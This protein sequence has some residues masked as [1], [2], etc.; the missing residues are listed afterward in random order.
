MD[1]SHEIDFPDIKDK[2]LLDVM[3]VCLQWLTDWLTDCFTEYVIKHMSAPLV[4]CN[5]HQHTFGLTK[6]A[7]A[8]API[9]FVWSSYP[10]FLVTL[11]DLKY[12]KTQ[13]S[14]QSDRSFFKM[15]AERIPALEKHLYFEKWKIYRRC[16]NCVFGIV[17]FSRLMISGKWLLR[18]TFVRLPRDRRSQKLSE[19]LSNTGMTALWILFQ[20]CLRRDPKERYTI[21]HLLTH[22]F[23]NSSSH[24]KWFKKLWSPIHFRPWTRLCLFHGIVIFPFFQILWLKSK[25]KCSTVWWSLLKL[26]SIPLAQLELSARQV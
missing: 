13:R 21:P 8:L 14:R 16:W 10:L 1:P 7:A 3:K 12:L 9:S 19:G 22:P 18:L 20:G 15:A 4:L 2:H 24:G 6:K 11:I 23:I 5:Y 26:M 25:I 17:K